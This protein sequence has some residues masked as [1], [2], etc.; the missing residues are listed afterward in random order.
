MRNSGWLP[1]LLVCLS[2]AWTAPGFSNEAPRERRPNI[3]L[4]LADDLGYPYHGFMGSEIVLTPNLDQLAAEGTV[5][6]HAHSSAT[7]CQAALQTL[8]T[9]LHPRSWRAQ[10]TRLEDTTGESF[11]RR[12]E[13][14]RYV[15]LPRELARM[16]YRTFQGGKHWEGNFEMAGFGQ[17]TTDVRPSYLFPFDW[18][19][20]GR[21]TQEP[22]TDFLDDVGEDEPFFVYFAPMLP[23]HP[24][25]AIP[26]LLNL[27]R[28]EGLL[29][30][31]AR[32]YANVSWFDEVVGRM[33]RTLEERG[34]RDDTLII[35]VSDN[36]WEQ[37]PTD[38]PRNQTGG[39]RGKLSMYEL[40]FRSPLIFSWPGRVPENE[41][42]EDLVTFKDLHATMLQ[43]AGAP[44]PPDHEGH[45]LRRRIRGR[46]DPDRDQV[47]GFQDIL[48]SRP[49]EP[50]PLVN[51]RF[52]D[53]GF[54]RT[55]RWRYIEW[56]DRGEQ[57]LYEIAEDPFERNDVGPEHPELL[58]EF[59]DRTA[60]WREALNEPAPWIDLMGR[61]TTEDQVP[62]PGLRLWLDGVQ[63]QIR[64]EILSDDRGFFRFPNVP[65]DHYRLSH[66][67]ERPADA[68]QWRR[69]RSRPATQSRLIDLTG[70]ETGPFL[71]LR[72]PGSAPPI[73]PGPLASSAIEV[74]VVARGDVTTSGRPVEV[75]GF[76]KRGYLKQRVLTGPDGF[77]VLDQLPVGFY[78]VKVVGSTGVRS[79]ARWVYLDQGESE[80]LR[81]KLRKKKRRNGRWSK[82]F[83]KKFA[84]R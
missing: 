38:R 65:A 69:S 59:A 57:E 75:T 24:H 34:L 68:G 15:T 11:P 46:G 7:Y 43:Y 47:V 80:P 76:T 74:E 10:R 73:P 82:A 39:D 26:R 51:L 41:R 64:F 54:L 70:F 56:L 18:Y 60:A 14:Q 71:P 8:L 48:R 16:G 42:R 53:A 77:V 1:L 49:D 31:A 4:I 61:L 32:Y 79:R 25:N 30:V 28:I 3:V 6:T 81:F 27:Y 33:L 5:F 67:L 40:G 45:P 20:F 44:I 36:G 23:H 35:Y 72:I 22:L 66:E 29:A 21:R 63:S 9:G 55:D 50:A 12:E 19:Q 84:S 78:I 13:V 2:L 52:E 62:A 83:R 58:A 17:G 37:S